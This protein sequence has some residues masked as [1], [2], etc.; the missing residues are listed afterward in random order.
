MEGV[1]E[2]FGVDEV[3]QQ[4]A[5][6]E[7]VGLGLA[8]VVKVGKVVGAAEGKPEVGLGDKPSRTRPA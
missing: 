2:A 5:G 7:A 3:F 4:E 1:A 6:A 8:I